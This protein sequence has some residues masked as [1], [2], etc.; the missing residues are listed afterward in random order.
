[1]YKRNIEARWPN[2]FAVRKQDVGITYFESVAV[3][4]VTQRKTRAILYCHLWPVSL[5]HTFHV[6]S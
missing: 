1:M 2:Q 4:L 5:Y 6:I 3:A